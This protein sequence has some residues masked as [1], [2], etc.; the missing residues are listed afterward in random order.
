MTNID[1]TSRPLGDGDWSAALVDKATG[2]ELPL[3]KNGWRAS[4]NRGDSQVSEAS[5]V[6]DPDYVRFLGR[7]PSLWTNELVLYRDRLLSWVGPVTSID[8]DAEDG[9]VWNCQDRMAVVVNRRWFWR[10]GTYSGDIASLMTIA[11]AAADYGDPTGLV[12]QPIPTGTIAAMPVVAGDLIGDALSALGVSWTVIGETV[13]Y[14]EIYEDT[15]LELGPRAWGM[16]RPT[17]EADGYRQLTHVCAVTDQGARIFYP[18]VDPNDRPPGKP[19]LVDTLDVGDVDAPAARD[20][21]KLAWIARQGELSI[22]PEAERPVGP[23]FPLQ[24]PYLIPGLVLSATSEGQQLTADG[25]PVKLATVN[26]EIADSRETLV[27]VG[28][29]E[30][31]QAGLTDQTLV[32]IVESSQGTIFPVGQVYP[33][34]NPYDADWAA[35][36]IFPGFDPIPFNGIDWVG[37]DLAPIDLWDPGGETGPSPE[38]VPFE[39]PDSLNGL[40]PDGLDFDFPEIPIDAIP[41]PNLPYPDPPVINPFAGCPPAYCCDQCDL[42]PEPEGGRRIWLSRTLQEGAVEWASADGVSLPLH[43]DVIP[44]IA[45]SGIIFGPQSGLHRLFDGPDPFGSLSG[46]ITW[47]YDISTWWDVT[48]PTTKEQFSSFQGGFLIYASVSRWDGEAGNP[49]A[50]PS[51]TNVAIGTGNTP[52]PQVAA[53]PAGSGITGWGRAYIRAVIDTATGDVELFF[54]PDEA[55]LVSQGTFN[56]AAVIGLPGQ[57]SVSLFPSFPQGAGNFKANEARLVLHGARLSSSVEGTIVEFDQADID[58]DPLI[59][60]VATRYFEHFIAPSGRVG[61]TLTTTPGPGTNTEIAVSPGGA[62]VWCRQSTDDAGPIVPVFAAAAA[63]L[64]IP[65]VAY[66]NADDPSQIFVASADPKALTV[67]ELTNPAGGGFNIWAVADLAEFLAEEIDINGWPAGWW[68]F[69]SRVT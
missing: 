11:L 24:W 15:G 20:L 19:L 54:G 3:E 65:V 22:I 5:L 35:I 39:F 46:T 41:N 61:T 31:P 63:D 69:G 27:A 30:A 16:D 68:P 33:G 2:T 38:L 6:L 36:G 58:A 8:D 59:Y 14:G 62:P 40:L 1:T 32:N 17:L 25:I 28:V 37:L 23:D 45:D 18:S 56:S 67:A 21:A 4:A 29:N 48:N 47:E 26:A 66:S 49:E 10:S 7:R 55:G 44:H 52:F 43:A 51:P 64:A 57:K 34:T 9:V 60:T 53:N 13:R 12:R 42:T 50:P